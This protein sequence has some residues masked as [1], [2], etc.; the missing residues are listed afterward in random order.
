VHHALGK[1]GVAKRSRY[2]IARNST[3]CAIR[4]LPE[5]NARVVWAGMRRGMRDA[6]KRGYVGPYLKG[7]AAAIAGLPGLLRQ[8]RAIQSTRRVSPADVQ[9]FLTG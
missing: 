4:N 8:R 1:S 6:R 7:K 2:W 3:W 9:A 5:V